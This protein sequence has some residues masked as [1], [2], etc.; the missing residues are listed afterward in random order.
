MTDLSQPGVLVPTRETS[1]RYSFRNQQ[2]SQLVNSPLINVA[3][4]T[5]VANLWARNKHSC[6]LF[7]HSFCATNKAKYNRRECEWLVVGM[8]VAFF[9]V[10]FGGF[11]S[12]H[13]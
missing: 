3:E 1:R 2:T 10:A 4:K 12:F 13:V 9:E 5:V 8:V 6:T 11:R 7:Y